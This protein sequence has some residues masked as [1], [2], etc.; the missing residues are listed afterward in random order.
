[1]TWKCHKHKSFFHN[2]SHFLEY[3]TPRKLIELTGFCLIVHAISLKTLISSK[4]VFF[5][6]HHLNP[7]IV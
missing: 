2:T 4:M 5:E 7:K 1:M 6:I 3:I